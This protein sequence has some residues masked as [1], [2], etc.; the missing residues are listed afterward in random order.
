MQKSSGKYEFIYVELSNDQFN[1]LIV[2][3]GWAFDAFEIF[4]DFLLDRSVIDL[5]FE[6][7]DRLLRV[8]YSK[9][10]V[11][12]KAAEKLFDDAFQDCSAWI[13]RNKK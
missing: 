11:S 6:F 7:K 5:D 13:K 3:H 9:D 1:R 12:K 4:I 10:I 2:I 8:Y